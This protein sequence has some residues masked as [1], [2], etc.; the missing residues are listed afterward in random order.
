[1]KSI[2]LFFILTSI[3]I[4]IASGCDKDC[5]QDRGINGEWIWIKSVGGFSGGTITPDDVG[6]TEKLKIDD[7]IYQ[8]YVNDTLAYESQYDLEI[9]EDSIS[10]PRNYL[11]FPSGYEE[12]IGISESE[13][14][15]DEI[16]YDDGYTRYYQRD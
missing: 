10:G 9:R 1:M 2:I 7:F 13:L 3:T 12:W 4:F 16:M 5:L 8:V 6:Y 15:L 14:V 11:V